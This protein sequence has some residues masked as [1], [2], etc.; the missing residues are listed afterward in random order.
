MKLVTCSVGARGLDTVT[1]LD[2]AV[3]SRLKSASFDFAVRYLGGIDVAEATAILDAALGLQ[4]VTYS[5]APGWSPSASLGTQ[6]GQTDVSQA[7][8][9]GAR[10]S[11]T[12]LCQDIVDTFGSAWWTGAH[13]RSAER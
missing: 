9:S 11:W 7:Q 1:T 4:V 8:G 5:A 3:A 12:H 6:D 13:G 10:T 2:A